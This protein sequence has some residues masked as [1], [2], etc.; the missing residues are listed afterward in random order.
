MEDKVIICRCQDVSE[1]EVVEVIKKYD[2]RSVDEV[3]R[4]TRAG[5]GHCQGK[6]CRSLV[7]QILKREQKERAIIDIQPTSRP[8]TKAVSLKK[9]AEAEESFEKVISRGRGGH[10]D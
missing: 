7:E 6:T 1:E 4:M 5:M 10:N 3:K 9:Y 8:P 2:L